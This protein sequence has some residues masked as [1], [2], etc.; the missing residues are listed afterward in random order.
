[1]PVYV[2]LECTHCQEHLDDQWS[3][4]VGTVHLECDNGG[5]WSRVYT[6]TR[7]PAPGAHPSEKAIV[8]VSAKEGGRV[9]YPG[10]ADQ[11]MP[12]RLKARGY[13]RVEIS[14]PQ[15]GA[16]EKKHRVMNERRH[17]D[18]NGKTD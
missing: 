4:M 7:G 13:E 16:F 3:S 10:R 5:V 9:Q 1:M 2:D 15:M 17:F 18:R 6:L 12:D 8:Y 11:P 14:P